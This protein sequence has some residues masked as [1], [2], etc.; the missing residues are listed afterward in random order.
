MANA[1]VGRKPWNPLIADQ[2]PE[3]DQGNN[4]LL[5]VCKLV[6]HPPSHK[7]G[8]SVAARP[9]AGGNVEAPISLIVT[10]KPRMS[11]TGANIKHQTLKLWGRRDPEHG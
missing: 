4:V 9:A 11:S 8:D 6:D 2:A 3:L 7:P 10:N 1:V 5:T